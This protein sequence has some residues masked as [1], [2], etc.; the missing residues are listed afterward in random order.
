MS[1]KDQEVRE[2][3]ATV[4]IQVRAGVELE[5]R[6]RI[7]KSL[8]KGYKVVEIHPRIL[9]RQ[10]RCSRCQSVLEGVLRR[11]GLAVGCARSGTPLGIGSIRRDLSVARHGYSP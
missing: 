3:D 1:R 6:S 11:P 2:I 4:S 7:T 10:D 5:I 8:C 9:V